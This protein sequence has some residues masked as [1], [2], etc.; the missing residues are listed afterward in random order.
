MEP[1][2][3]CKTPIETGLKKVLYWVFMVTALRTGAH[4][5]GT[6]AVASNISNVTLPYWHLIEKI[7]LALLEKSLCTVDGPNVIQLKLD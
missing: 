6:I 3:F 5:A 4:T 2:F 7:C 1:G